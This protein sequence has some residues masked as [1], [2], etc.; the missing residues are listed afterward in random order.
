MSLRHHLLSGP[1]GFPLGGE[2]GAETLRQQ[3]SGVDKQEPKS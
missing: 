2:D 1:G 3:E